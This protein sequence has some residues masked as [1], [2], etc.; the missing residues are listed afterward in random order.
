MIDKNNSN[1]N[2]KQVQKLTLSEVISEENL[3]AG[4][5]ILKSGATPGVDGVVKAEFKDNQIRELQKSLRNHT[6]KPSPTKRVAIPKLNGGTRYL[7]VSTT[8]DKIVQ[9]AVYLKLKEIVNSG[10][11]ADSYGFRP[12]K[13]C[14][15]ALN[16]LK[17]KWQACRFNFYPFLRLYY[18]Y[19]TII[20][21]FS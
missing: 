1:N 4:Y 11:S 5:A 15:D 2:M 19:E 16:S 10:F 12:N 14:H 20:P 18:F 3:K 8:R 7:A 21:N 13:G 17:Y 6:Y 9:A